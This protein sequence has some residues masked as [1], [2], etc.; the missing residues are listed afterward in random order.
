MVG[1]KGMQL[2][3]Q[4]LITPGNFELESQKDFFWGNGKVLDKYWGISSS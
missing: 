3:P 2:L 1:T 4:H